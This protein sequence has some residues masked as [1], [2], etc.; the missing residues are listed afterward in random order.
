MQAVAD[1]YLHK[2]KEMA[3]GAAAGTRGERTERKSWPASAGIAGTPKK[4]LLHQID[5]CATAA[6]TSET[7]RTPSGR[8]NAR[9]SSSEAIRPLVR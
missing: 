6:C 5:S 9:S 8:R 1:G 4:A 3:K 7:G 2:H